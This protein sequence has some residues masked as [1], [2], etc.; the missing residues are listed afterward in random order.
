MARQK[1]RPAPATGTNNE[2]LLQLAV[3][4]AK[5]GNKD[6]ARVMFKQVYDRDKRS[7]RALYGLA[8]VARSPRERQQWLKQ[9]LKVNPGHEVALAALKKANYQSTASQN[10]TLVIGIVIVVVLVILLLG[11]L[12]L[13]TSL[14]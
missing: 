11:I 8:Q 5:Q 9:L 12:Y 6:S 14:R 1:S 2:Q 10:R 3:N 4:A 7:E 13:V